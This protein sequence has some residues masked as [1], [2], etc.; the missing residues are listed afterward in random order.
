MELA[1]Y[2]PAQ[3]R[4]I[5]LC[6]KLECDTPI[7]ESCWKAMTTW[8]ALLPMFCQKLESLGFFLV[9]DP[10]PINH[11]RYMVE[12]NKQ[13]GVQC[14]LGYTGLKCRISFWKPPVKCHTDVRYR[15]TVNIHPFSTLC[16]YFDTV[17]A[18]FQSFDLIWSV[19]RGS[20]SAEL[21]GDLF[22]DPWKKKINA[23]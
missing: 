3:L 18:M 20:T 5:G 12:G 15:V 21:W 2:L 9:G 17:H 8:D 6:A 7:L 16:F 14:N 10:V 11:Y 23:N 13:V 1:P 19:S 4:I 22:S